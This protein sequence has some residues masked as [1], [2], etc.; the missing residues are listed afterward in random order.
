MGAVRWARTQSVSGRDVSLS[1]FY[2]HQLADMLQ[3]CCVPP[4]CWTCSTD[5]LNCGA[6]WS[7]S[8]SCVTQTVS[9]S[10]LLTFGPVA[11]S[12]HID[13]SPFG[14]EL[15]FP[16]AFIVTHTRQLY[17]WPSL[18]CRSKW[19]KTDCLILY[20]SRSENELHEQCLWL[21]W[22]SECPSAISACR[23]QSN[24][25]PVS[26]NSFSCLTGDLSIP[27]YQ[28]FKGLFALP[29]RWKSQLITDEITLA[30]L[31]HSRRWGVSVSNNRVQRLEKV[32]Q[33]AAVTCLIVPTLNMSGSGRNCGVCWECS[34]LYLLNGKN[35]LSWDWRLCCK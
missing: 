30:T 29:E 35:P 23:E 24:L 3:K 1:G 4:F 33:A 17:I 11:V 6:R 32:Q 5:T 26:L 22:A 15:H 9:D 34:S 8:T 16:L 12:K 7:R 2:L 13:M 14:K 28:W 19:N 25:C 20:D 31:V 27:S 21:H 10:R 18:C